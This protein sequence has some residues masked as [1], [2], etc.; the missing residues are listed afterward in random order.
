M[1]DGENEEILNRYEYDA[2]GNLTT[3]EEKVPNRFKFNGQQYDP[4][5]QQYYLRARYYNPVIGRFTQEDTYNVDGLNLYAYCRNNPV[6]YVD[7][8][9]NICGRR[10]NTLMDNVLSGGQLTRKEKRQLAAK[11]RDEARNGTISDKGR[12]VARQMGIDLGSVE[13]Y[14]NSA[15]QRWRNTTDTNKGDSETKTL[16]HYTNEKGM[17]AIVESQQLNPSLIM[18]SFW[19]I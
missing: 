13:S 8:S 19:Q 12:D 11:L 7:P 1:V 9:V 16:Y 10:A 2:W 4:I 14:N 5:S 15:D 6:Y 3:C 17:N 18:K